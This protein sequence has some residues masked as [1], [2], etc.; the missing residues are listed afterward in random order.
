MS[1]FFL[2]FMNFIQIIKFHFVKVTITNQKNHIAATFALELEINMCYN[3]NIGLC[4]I[5]V[6]TYISHI[7]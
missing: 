2:I 7:Q 5:Y 3:K 6:V 4:G 1:V